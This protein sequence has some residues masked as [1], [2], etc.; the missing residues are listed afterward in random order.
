MS[1]RMS[2]RLRLKSF[3]HSANLRFRKS[4]SKQEPHSRI[5]SEIYANRMWGGARAQQLDFCSGLGSFPDNSSAY[6]DVVVQFI[7]NNNVTSIVDVGCGDFQVSQRILEKI[8][9]PIRYIGVDV[10]PDLIE[11]NNRLFASE[12]IS[13]QVADA[14]VD[15]LP[16]A[17]LLITREVL[18]HLSND[19]IQVVLEKVRSYPFALITNGVTKKPI[20]KNIDIVAGASTRLSLGS[21][22]WIEGPPFNFPCSE[23]F[24]MAHS[25]GGA[26]LRTV[27][28]R[29]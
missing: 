9:R 4:L 19:S 12:F 22:L 3:V 27:A 26:D 23:L 7:N 10:V 16:A 28:Y 21:G 11:R 25:G 15:P 5:F 2:L 18:Q 6:E 17:D 24:S 20:R 14:V 29:R 1:L 8:G 13:F